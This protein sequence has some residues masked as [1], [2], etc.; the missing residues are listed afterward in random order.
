MSGGEAP[1]RHGDLVRM[2]WTR[3]RSAEQLVGHDV[4]VELTDGGQQA[5]VLKRL[6][7]EGDHLLLRSTA[8]GYDD[9]EGSPSMRVVAELVER[10]DPRLWNPLEQF[11]GQPF[12][13]D[14]IPGL[15]GLEFNTGK[16]GSP[17]QVSLEDDTVM[18]STIEQ[19]KG[20]AGENYVNQFESPDTFRWSS[21]LSTG[22]D[23]KRG[24]EVTESLET[25]R[26]IHLFVR[27]RRQDG[28]YTYC[29]IGTPLR[30][31][32]DRPMSVWFSLL[33]PLSRDLQRQ[34][35]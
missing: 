31:E 1:I 24:R 13:R 15:F 5:A 11:I 30:H 22:P 14:A 7:R 10:V 8:S 21:Q 17:G 18:M 35:L 2:R 12:R 19:E 34:L 23:G 29:G 27:R 26:R 6:V 25:G 33:T 4:L 3:S 28:A 20:R 9:I 32:G 16:W